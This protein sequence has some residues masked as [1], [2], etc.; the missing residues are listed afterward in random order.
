VSTHLV[1]PCGTI[2]IV[3]L[4][5][6]N[7][8]A[9]LVTCATVAASNG[10]DLRLTLTLLLIGCGPAIQAGEPL[11]EVWENTPGLTLDVR[12]RTPAGE[13]ASGVWV[14]LE[15]GGRD[16]LTD[17]AGEATFIGLDEG[18]YTASF[19]VPGSPREIHALDL[20]EDAEVDWT[21]AQPP[22]AF[23][24][25]SV[26]DAVGAPVF[27]AVVQLGE[28]VVAT[29][30]EGGFELPSPGAGTYTLTV[31]GPG[32]PGARFVSDQVQL[33]DHADA[34]VPVALPGT[35]D[36]DATPIGSEVCGVCHADQVASWSASAHGQAV[37]SHT[38]LADH[39]IASAVAAG[40]AIPL[41]GPVLAWVVDAEDGWRVE[42]FDGFDDFDSYRVTRVVG[43][44]GPGAALLGEVGGREVVLPVAWVAPGEGLGDVPGGF[45]PAWT[46]G[47]LDGGG[48]RSNPDPVDY[49][50]SC[51][52]CHSTGAE[53]VEAGSG[54]ALQPAGD[55]PVEHAVGCE[56]CH[57]DGLY[58]RRLASRRPASI[59]N[60]ARLDA[61]QQ[62]DVCARC[63]A[64][65]DTADHPFADQ[66][67]WP[68]T[69]D[70]RMPN[71]P[72]MLVPDRDAYA[73]VFASRVFADQV[74]DLR[75]SPHHTGT[76]RGAC[77]DCHVA[78]GSEHPA[79]LRAEPRDPALCTTCHRDLTSAFAQAEHNRHRRFA[80]GAWSPGAC[81]DCHFPRGPLV[82]RP[83]PLSGVGEHR[84][85]TLVP[86]SG[87]D[88]V[89]AF[90]EAGTTTLSPGEVAVPPCLDCHL[91]AAERLWEFGQPFPGPYGDPYVRASHENLGRMQAEMWGER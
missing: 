53:L 39:P 85:H 80:P 23:V 83:D 7:G 71:P 88:T 19:T 69:E 50:L 41:S 56:A 25:G 8:E 58:H 81:I 9:R 18:A 27:G 26:T 12:V 76:Y 91:Q 16:A 10:E 36:P 17:K 77:T 89:A 37:R 35:I 61:G 5:A 74:G 70:G 31:V 54:Y 32:S 90:D 82:L 2:V 22:P 67:A 15:P 24:R 48:L 60:P 86:W 87:A 20:A 84:A 13:P 42:I 6:T 65:V 4:A 52:G 47:W 55:V 14:V 51:G 46:D 33:L 28:D 63:H 49:A 21:A 64:R 62:L 34:I 68:V 29:N 11:P 75:T 66:P 72:G 1:D 45:I 38:D 3:D 79:D 30:I 59:V 43:G 57:G 40:E 44:H 78:H 73:G